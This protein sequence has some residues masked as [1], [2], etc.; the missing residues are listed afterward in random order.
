MV[1][2][3][4]QAWPEAKQQ[5]GMGEA[6]PGGRAHSGWWPSSSTAS[7]W[8]TL[9]QILVREALE[10]RGAAWGWWSK[11]RRRW[12]G[13]LVERLCTMGQGGGALG[14]TEAVRWG[15]GGGSLGGRELRA[16]GRGG[17]SLGG[18]E[19]HAVGQGGSGGAIRE[20]GRGG[21]VIREGGGGGGL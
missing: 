19:L 4:A 2:P 9:I 13:G 12:S 3:S 14:G 8:M 15:R 18:R 7:T 10:G 1:G 6:E 21:G 11:A 5:G 20:G 17:G 16:V